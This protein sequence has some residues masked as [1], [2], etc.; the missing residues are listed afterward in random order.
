V[1]N[2]FTVACMLDEA[3]VPAGEYLLQTAAGSVLGRQVIQ[4]ARAAGIKTINTVRRR[5]QVAELKALGAD[6]VVCTADE[7][8]VARVK[9]I[10]GGRGA[11]AALDAVAGD[12]VE[13]VVASLRAGGTAFVY[14]AMA[15]LGLRASVVDILFRGCAVRGFWVTAWA[16]A[17]GTAKVH[18]LAARLWASMQAGVLTPYAGQ[19]FDA[20]DVKAAL[21]TATATARGG[22]VL[23]RFS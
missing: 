5:E 12:G 22:K 4:L 9:E 10:T 15:G 11:Y 1:V 16:A 8:L 6:E 7:D 21:A 23:L 17:A 14:G 13:A 2:P 19:V 18:A 3:A 20:A